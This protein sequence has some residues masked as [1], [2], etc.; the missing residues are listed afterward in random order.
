[1][2]DFHAIDGGLC[3]Q[4]ERE[5]ISA[6]GE[7]GLKPVLDGYFGQLI[8]RLPHTN[9]G[10]LLTDRQVLSQIKATPGAVVIPL[11]DGA[12]VTIAHG[13]VQ[14]N[15][16]E[17]KCIIQSLIV[18][19]PPTVT[20]EIQNVI[21]VTQGTMNAICALSETDSI[22]ASDMQRFVNGF[23]TQV[24]QQKKHQNITITKHGSHYTLHYDDH[25]GHTATVGMWAV[26]V[27]GSVFKTA[28]GVGDA[29]EALKKLCWVRKGG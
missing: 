9:A 23:V 16:T 18:R 15:G 4:G 29:L 17:C 3:L 7:Y 6:Y 20:A 11:G 22:K 28:G 5:V 14:K 13:A 24:M 2:E 8:R 19:L 1:M 26:H 25:N 10:K 27:P 21:P 12:T